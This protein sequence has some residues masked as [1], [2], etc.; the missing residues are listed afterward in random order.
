MTPSSSTKE[1]AMQHADANKAINDT[2]P[3]SGKPVDPEALMEH[4][5]H[6]V[7]FC[8][9]EHRD[10]FKKAIDHFSD[11]VAKQQKRA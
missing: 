4:N 10:Q 3:W 1:A 11:A 6:I 9:R 8:S 2:C 5:G 7:G